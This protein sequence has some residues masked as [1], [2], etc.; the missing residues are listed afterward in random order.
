M[1]KNLI[2]RTIRSFLWRTG[3]GRLVASLFWRKVNG[4]PG[5]R[6]LYRKSTTVFDSLTYNF[7]SSQL[8]DH[9]R[10]EA[11]EWNNQEE[12]VLEIENAI[13][14][15]ERCL[16]IRNFNQLVEQSVVY[17][18][19]YQY[20]FIL[21]YLL[22]KANYV[23][24]TEAVLY[25]GS[26]TRSYYHHFVNAVN[27]IHMMDKVSLPGNIPFIISREMF[28][29]PFFQYLYNKSA[30]FRGLNWLVQ[31]ENQWLKVQRLYKLQSVHFA[32]EPWMKTKKLYDSK[33]VTP[34]RKVFLSRDRKLYSRGLI[35]EEEIISLLAGFGFET[36][37]AEHLPIEEQA[38]I[39][40]E[41]KYLVALTGMGL[42]QQFFMDYEK[43]SILEVTPADRIVSEY[44]WLSNALG[45]SYFDIIVGTKR[46]F[47]GNYYVN[48]ELL[49]VQV[50]KMLKRETPPVV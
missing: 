22:P 15:P 47:N 18:A 39:F 30:K 14:E 32:R 6:Y 42:V 44:F 48:P 3:I 49:K 19:T 9:L 25:D 2:S 45:I 27:S 21:E 4:G 33:N 46:N 36:I 41:T 11:A 26:A 16:A 34:E 8:V 29:K 24:I 12:Y 37:Y 50:L 7:E 31:E 20:P 35:N 43:A 23:R 28:E 5:F 13:V 38:K 40:A 17:R 10:A 1:N